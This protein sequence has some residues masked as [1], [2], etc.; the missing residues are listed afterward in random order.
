MM[1]NNLLIMKKGKA[2][3]AKRG[4]READERWTLWGTQGNF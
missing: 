3:G 2:V 4:D 1:F